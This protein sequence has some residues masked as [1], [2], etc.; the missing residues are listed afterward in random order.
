MPICTYLEPLDIVA[1]RRI[2]TEP[3]NAII[4]QYEKLFGMEGVE[5]VVQQEALDFIAETALDYQ[6]GARG[7]RSLCEAIFTDAMFNLPSAANQ[8]EKHQLVIDREY[9]AEKLEHSR[10]G[11]LKAA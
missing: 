2:L 6:L 11:R 7:L 9:V 8:P 4:R 1:L 10:I 3:R 5:L